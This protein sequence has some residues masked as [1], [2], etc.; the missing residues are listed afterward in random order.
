MKSSIIIINPL[1]IA[2]ESIS[3]ALNSHHDLNVVSECS[4]IKDALRA[5]LKHKHDL[6]IIE[7]LERCP[8]DIQKISAVN[9]ATKVV[10]SGLF[11]DEEAVVACACAGAS[12]YVDA[13]ASEEDWV[14]AIVGAI[15]NEITNPKV[16]AMLNHYLATQSSFHVNDTDSLASWHVPTSV[17]K[18]AARAGLTPRERQIVSLIDKGLS[19]KQIAR[20]LNLEPSTVKNHVHS[21]LGKYQVRRRGEAAAKFRESQPREEK[22]SGSTG[23]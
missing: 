4:T 3:R 22:R 16:G 20:Q 12:G 13:S 11:A 21:I 1:R 10:V 5:I 19:N 7:M 15:H 17:A 6:A 9:P 14:V 23:S 2:R 8:S 18:S